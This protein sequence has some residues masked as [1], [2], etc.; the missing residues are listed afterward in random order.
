MVEDQG[1]IYTGQVGSRAPDLLPEDNGITK[2]A[3]RVELDGGDLLDVTS[4]INYGKTYT[5]EHDVK[6]L[7][8]GKVAP[9]HLALLNS[10]WKEAMW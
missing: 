5:V 1:V 3:L 6:V 7:S 2:G 9:E 8:V 4:R 10:N